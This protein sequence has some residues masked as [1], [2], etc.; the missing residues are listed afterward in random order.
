MIRFLCSHDD[1]TQVKALW[2]ACFGDSPAYIDF[3]TGKMSEAECVVFEQDQTIVSMLYLLKCNL[4][5]YSGR[6]IF[7]ACTGSSYRG[8]GIM[9]ALLCY[10]AKQYE[11]SCDFLCLVPAN[12]PLFSYYEKLGYQPYFY[13][14]IL[15]VDNPDDT[16]LAHRVLSYEEFAALR[17]EGRIHR[18]LLQWDKSVLRLLYDENIYNGGRNLKTGTGYAFLREAGDTCEVI[19]WIS[20]DYNPQ[21]LLPLTCCKKLVIRKPYEHGLVPHPNGM[22]RILNPAVTK[23]MQTINYPYLSLVLD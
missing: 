23:S 16:P 4:Q 2:S 21:E 13:N 5:Q 15:E 9:R 20:E 8:Q 11:A 1:L 17:C 18:P 19:E 10:T 6:Y 14:T 12:A 3:L 22:I 7:A